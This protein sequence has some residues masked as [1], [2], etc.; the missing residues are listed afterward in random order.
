RAETGRDLGEAGR[1]IEQWPAGLGRLDDVDDRNALAARQRQQGLRLVDR[2][3]DAVERQLAVDIFELGVDQDERGGLER[4][5]ME[6]GAGELQQST[7]KRSHGCLLESGCVEHGGW[8]PAREFSRLSP[9]MSEN[10]QMT[11]TGRMSAISLRS[12]G[13]AAFRRRRGRCASTT[14]RW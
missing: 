2:V 4:T 10:A 14:R 3:R 9:W 11:S 7:G 1:G 6:R 5:R 8:R 13:T 12:P